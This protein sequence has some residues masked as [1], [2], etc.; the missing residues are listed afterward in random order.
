MKTIRVCDDDG[1]CSSSYDM[2]ISDEAWNNRYINN[3]GCSFI[4]WEDKMYVADGWGNFDL[5]RSE[6]QIEKAFNPDRYAFEE[7]RVS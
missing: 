5:V 4:K 1:F 7:W 2:Q 3:N 6:E